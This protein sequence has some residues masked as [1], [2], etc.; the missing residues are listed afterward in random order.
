MTLDVLKLNKEETLQYL[1][2]EVPSYPEFEAWILKKNGGKLDRAAIEKHNAAVRGRMHDEKARKGILDAAGIKDEGRVKEIKD[3]ITLN[4]WDDWT[5]FHN[6]GRCKTPSGPATVELINGT[7]FIVL[8][9][10]FSGSFV[11]AVRTACCLSLSYLFLS[12]PAGSSFY[13]RPLLAVANPA[14]NYV[15]I[16]AL[17]N[18]LRQTTAIYLFRAKSR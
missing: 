16:S 11:E 4:D 7:I 6:R 1:H 3:A 8:S 5:E 10:H 2:S 12:F 17:G 9:F 13:V 15:F 14:R 18:G